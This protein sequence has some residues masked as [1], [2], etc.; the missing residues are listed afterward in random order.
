MRK[1]FVGVIVGFGLLAGCNMTHLE[2][3]P[4]AMSI[5]GADTTLI[6][7]YNF[8]SVKP[9]GGRKVEVTANL[10]V[11]DGILTCSGKSTYMEKAVTQLQMPI[12]CSDGTSGTAILVLNP[13]SWRNIELC[14]ETQVA[15][16]I[17]FSLL[18]NV[19]DGIDTRYDAIW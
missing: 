8:P 10:S 5:K 9:K 17:L 15:I 7:Q 3:P 14:E 2:G 12:S 1:V 16:H 4:A 11:S 18:N 6:G 19:L 13:D